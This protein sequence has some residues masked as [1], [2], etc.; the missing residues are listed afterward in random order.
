MILSNATSFSFSGKQGEMA[1]AAKPTPTIL[2]EKKLL[3]EVPVRKPARHEFVRVNDDPR[4]WEGQAL[5]IKL[6]QDGQI[7]L[8]HWS[9]AAELPREFVTTPYFLYMAINRQGWC[10]SGPC[11]GP[12]QTASTI[13]GTGQLPRRL[14]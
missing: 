7:Y 11:G 1:R 2:G 8:V 12:A 13:R 4:Y 14:G 6:R 10:S 3:T 5:I 9:L